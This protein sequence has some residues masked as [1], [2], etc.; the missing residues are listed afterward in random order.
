MAN[1]S[2][3]VQHVQA[4][5]KDV[6]RYAGVS[7]AVVSYVVNDVPNKVAP[8]TR[9]RVLEAIAVL[10]YRP[11]AA[12]R[13]LKLGSTEMI[14]LVVQES[15]N[16]YFAELAH[17]VEEVVDEL[18]YAMLLTNSGGVLDKERRHVRNFASRQVDGVLLASNLAEPDLSELD[19]AGIPVVLL[20]R[21]HPLPGRASVGV[22]FAEGARTGVAHL[23][24]HG[25]RVIGLVMGTDSNGRYDE[26]E[27]GW[28]RALQEAG[29]PEGPIVRSAF[30]R[31]GGYAAGARMIEMANRPTAIFVSSDMQAVGVLRALHEAGLSVP[32]DMAVVSFDGSPESEFSTPGL[33]TIKQPVQAMAEAAVK[34]LL[35]KDGPREHR[36][37]PTELVIR[38]S[39]GCTPEPG[40]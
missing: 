19:A 36:Q 2:P 21:A 23:V 14:G 13:A 11:N 1:S 9:E 32:A 4:T 34:A 40:A 30:T 25:H 6:G 16:P 12:A 37:F 35:S 28:L 27:V 3:P 22:D 33:T 39:C 8:A 31:S 18:G 10:G 20:D 26:R 24:E 17:E 38:R 29:L 5:R 15:S 7:T